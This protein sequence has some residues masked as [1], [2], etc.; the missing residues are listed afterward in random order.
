MPGTKGNILPVV[1][2]RLPSPWILR[3]TG[4]VVEVMLLRGQQAS[5]TFPHEVGLQRS[6]MTSRTRGTRGIR[7]DLLAPPDWHPLHRDIVLPQNPR[8]GHLETIKLLVV[9]DGKS[10]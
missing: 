10:P 4:V 8:R 3:H 2:S 1:S 6:H 5:A 7:R 9:A